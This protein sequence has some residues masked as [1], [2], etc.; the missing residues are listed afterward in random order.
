MVRRGRRRNV[1]TAVIAPLS[2]A[3][4]KII[5]ALHRRKGRSDEGAFIA[6]GER[7]LSEISEKAERVRWFFATGD[8]I[9]WLE[10]RFPDAEILLIDEEMAGLFATENTQG[11]GAVIDMLPQ[12]AIAELADVGKPL[13]MLDGVADPGNVGTILRTAEWFGIGG[14]LLGTGSVDLYNPKVVRATMGAIF[15]LP[16]VDGVNVQ[17][18]QSLDLSL[19]ALD[20]SATEFLGNTYLPQRAV[21]IIGSEAHGVTAE[22]LAISRRVAIRGAG[23]VESLNAA[24][25]AAVLCYELSRIQ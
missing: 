16:V 19:L 2:K 1:R 24:S 11:V 13:L 3:R 8:R 6:E 14:V 20:A 9:G 23:Y 10:E 17:S 5:R 7:L 15:R 12:P 21:Y 18:V 4:A 25:A 22:L